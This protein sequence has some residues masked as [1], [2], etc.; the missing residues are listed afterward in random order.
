MTVPE[1]TVRNRQRKI[2]VNVA[3]LE[4][5]A[6]NALTRCLRLKKA[7]STQLRKL[8]AIAVW[9]ISDR[10]ISQLHLRFFHDRSPTDVIT[11]QD[12]EIFISVETALRNA[13]I[14]RNSLV[15]E[16]KLDM[17]H[18]FLHLHGFDDRTPADLRRMHQTQ[19]RI[20]RAMGIQIGTVPQD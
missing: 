8:K 15:S 2:A 1:I 19:E 17:V 13:G 7:E 5:F 16:I 9:L 11:F 6:A 18:A 20:V 12:G 3:E 4:H 14:F 10:R